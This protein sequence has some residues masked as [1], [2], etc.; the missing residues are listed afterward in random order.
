MAMSVI[1]NFYENGIKN[2]HA[3]N[4]SKKF[5]QINESLSLVTYNLSRLGSLIQSTDILVTS[6]NSPLP[7]I[8]KG[9]I[10]N[11]MKERKNKE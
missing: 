4:R 5:L 1:Q 10:E 7:I 11:A 6:V 8:G 9:L 2:I 3:V